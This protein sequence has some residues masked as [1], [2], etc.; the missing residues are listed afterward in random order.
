MKS[1]MAGKEQPLDNLAALAKAGVPV[2]HDCGALDP[3]LDNQTR[4]VE[5][6]Y[7]ELD[8]KIT[9]IVRAG[10]GH[11]PLSPKDP[12][13]VVDFIIKNAPIPVKGDAPTSLYGGGAT[14]TDDCVKKQ[15]GD[16]FRWTGSGQI[17]WK[18]Q[19]D[20]AGEYEVALCHAAEPARLDCTCRSAVVAARSGTRWR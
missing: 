12:K 14:S 18:V 3:W 20:R 16:S 1:L 5:K 10:E 7:K 2:L 11:F 17:T 9:V 15:A 19:V 8:G 13:S 6:R 4:V